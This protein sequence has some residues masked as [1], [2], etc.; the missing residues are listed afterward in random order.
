PPPSQDLDFPLS[1]VVGAGWERGSGGEGLPKLPIQYAD[2]ARW[3]RRRLAGGFL[4]R[5][6][7]H[8]REVLAG[9]PETQELPYDRP[10]PVAPSHR[11]GR[12]PFVLPG[13]WL[14]ALR[15]LGRR[16]GWTLFMTLLSAFQAL[17]TRLGGQEDAVVGSPVANRNRLETEGL[18]G[19]FTNTLALRLD[20]SGD[21]AFREIG[22]RVR[23]VALDAYTHEDLPFERVVEELAPE[24]HPGLNP[25]FQVMLVVQ[26]P[27]S[28]ALALSGVTAELVDVEPEVAK[29]DLTFFL[30]EDGELSGAMEYSRDLF[31]EATIGRLLA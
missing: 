8:W 19:F 24:R 18:I 4:E 27:P 30:F 2:F 12:R 11:G 31:D 5:E 28:A 17:L 1:R 15:A 7:A 6:L 3:Q 21:P 13:E 14:A 20:L 22:R 10:R 9:A 29:F 23:A 26:R 16:E 25:L